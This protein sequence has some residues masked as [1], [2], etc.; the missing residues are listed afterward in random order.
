MA[1]P[2]GSFA[3]GVARHIGGVM[4]GLGLSLILAIV[5]GVV[6]PLTSW[7]WCYIVAALAG[8]TTVIFAFMFATLWW[9]PPAKT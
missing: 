7:V 4:Q 2:Y 8:A 1:N 5:A 9:P 6:A 3:L